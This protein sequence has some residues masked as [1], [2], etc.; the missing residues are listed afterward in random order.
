MTIVDFIT[1]LF[2][3]VDDKLSQHG[4]NHK[5]SQAKLYPSEVVTIAMLFALKGVG[6]RAS[7]RWIANNFKSLF[8]NTRAYPI[9]PL[10]R[11]ASTSH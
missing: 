7:Y 3:C 2:C 10:I 5:H 1:E 8:P 9:V 11:R 4:K 6:N